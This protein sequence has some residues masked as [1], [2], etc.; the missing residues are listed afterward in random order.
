MPILESI[1]AYLGIQLPTHAI[2]IAIFLGALFLA[3]IIFYFWP[4]SLLGFRLRRLRNSL[5][6]FKQ[7][8]RLEYPAELFNRG[9]LLSHLWVEYKETLHEQR[10]LNA[11]TG[12]EELV[13]IRATM[14]AEALFNPSVLVDSQL[15]VE[16]FKHLPGILTGL[17]II[18]TFLGLIQGLRAFQISENTQVVR[19]SLDFLLHG[20][21]EA[22]LVSVTAIG[23]AMLITFI[24]KWLLSWLYR[25]VEEL[26]FLIDSLYQA[27]A[28]EE[29]LERLV[30]ASESSA[31]Q[32]NIIQPF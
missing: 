24:E 15:H 27:G 4:A 12:I 30:K 5:R 31:S 6:A 2:I 20:V 10:S 22:F 23:L 25:Q 29:Y 32:A 28:G 9:K 16:F 18:G 11:Q 14:S 21:Y 7:S 1:N 26:C 13:A 3:F 19:Q 17:G 8:N